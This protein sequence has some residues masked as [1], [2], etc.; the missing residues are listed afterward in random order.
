MPSAGLLAALA[1]ACLTAAPVRHATIAGGD[2][3]TGGGLSFLRTASLSDSRWSR[4]SAGEAS[5]DL[6]GACLARGFGLSAGAEVASLA[7]FEQ[8]DAL[9]AARGSHA[10]LRIHAT[11]AFVVSSADPSFF[12]RP[13]CLDGKPARSALRPARCPAHGPTVNA[14]ATRNWPGASEKSDRNFFDCGPGTSKAQCY[15]WR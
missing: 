4:I 7:G 6:S 9:A 10:A 3:F 1:I 2:S 8:V 11:R 15:A 12:G 13:L 14:R 5:S